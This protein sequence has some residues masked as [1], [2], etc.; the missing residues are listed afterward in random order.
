MGVLEQSTLET[1]FVGRFQF[2][3]H[4]GKKADATLKENLRRNLTPRE[5]EIA[6][7]DL[8]HVAAI[9]DA[10]IETFKPAAKQYNAGALGYFPDP[11]LR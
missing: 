6:D 10:L 2:A 3:H 11:A 4:A 9:N 1:L 8:F 7:R 5:D